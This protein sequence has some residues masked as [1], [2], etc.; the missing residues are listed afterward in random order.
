MTK[1]AR[2]IE[3]ASGGS[4]GL[5]RFVAR[6]HHR[7]S[8]EIRGAADG[9][10]VL[11][12]HDLLTPHGDLHALAADGLRLILPDA[13]GHGASSTISGRNYPMRELAADD[14]AILD[15]EGAERFAVVA[16]GWSAAIAL[17]LA[18]MAPG[19]VASVTLVAPYLPAV[20]VQS[21]DPETH[22]LGA[23]HEDRL[24]AAADAADRG[25]RDRAIDLLFGLRVG[26]NWRDRLSTSQ[27]AA[28]RRGAADLAPLLN[29]SLAAFRDE[30]ALS[31]IETP[32]RIM[33]S[34]DAPRVVKLVSARL[35]EV[36][37]RA[38]INREVPPGGELAAVSAMLLDRE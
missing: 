36:L 32:V 22:D 8:Y 2:R 28:A 25:Q 11:G 29:G 15:A 19:R 12:L 27:Q 9:W 17:A 23:E 26:A 21:T 14:L 6:G 13:R 5:T 1:D 3:A 16:V 38:V 10:P 4:Q 7:L 24:H 35:D 37:P 33:F 34:A 31:A 20:L 18:T 30:S